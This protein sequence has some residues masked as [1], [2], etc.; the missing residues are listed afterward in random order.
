MYIVGYLHL[1]QKTAFLVLHS[2]ILDFL[3]LSIAFKSCKSKSYISFL[4]CINFLNEN[5]NY[6]DIN[7]EADIEIFLMK[8]MGI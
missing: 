8:V 5:K 3:K 2:D 6:I 1:Y 7:K 4:Y